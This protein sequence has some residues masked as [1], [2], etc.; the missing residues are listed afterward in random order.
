MSLVARMARFI[1]WM[2]IILICALLLLVTERVV[3]LAG[4]QADYDA[5]LTAPSLTSTVSIHRDRYGI[6]HIL[7]K[8][9]CRLLASPQ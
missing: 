7:G 3:K 6:P 4:T 9:G 1:L 8:D 5:N 2:L